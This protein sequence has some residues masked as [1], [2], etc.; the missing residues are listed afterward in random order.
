LEKTLHELKCHLLTTHEMTQYRRA[1]NSYPH[2][3]LNWPRELFNVKFAEG[4]DSEYPPGYK[5]LEVIDNLQAHSGNFPVVYEAQLLDIVEM[6]EKRISRWEPA[7][8][9]MAGS[10]NF[11]L[12]S[13]N[14]TSERAQFIRSFWYHLTEECA[15]YS[16]RNSMKSVMPSGTDW[17]KPWSRSDD[18]IKAIMNTSIVLT[19][20][21]EIDDGDVRDAID[22]VMKKE[23]LTKARGNLRVQRQKISRRRGKEPV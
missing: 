16:V 14:T 17:Q 7:M 19:G 8:G 10:A 23:G 4:D 21:E 3:T 1:T 15:F 5:P 11:A 13:S 12:L 2:L 20:D 6:L 22:F 9:L 18:V